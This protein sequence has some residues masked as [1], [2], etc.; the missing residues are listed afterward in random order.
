MF[1]TKGE[2]PGRCAA[3]PRFAQESVM[4]ELE[5]LAGPV[6]HSVRLLETID[7]ATLNER[8]LHGALRQLVGELR[9]LYQ[10][11]AEV[12]RVAPPSSSA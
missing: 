12:Q 7:P 1:D 3:C 11:V 4:V 9:G 10:R 6:A 8:R 5:L 2:S